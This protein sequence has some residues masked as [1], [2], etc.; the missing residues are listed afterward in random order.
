MNLHELFSDQ[1]YVWSVRNDRAIHFRPQATPQ[2]IAAQAAATGRRPSGQLDRTLQA[3]RQSELQV[4]Q[5]VSERLANYAQVR[6]ILE[7]ISEINHEL[8]RRREPL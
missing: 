4:R 1:L 6:E 8:L 5:W 3:L 2:A 7:E